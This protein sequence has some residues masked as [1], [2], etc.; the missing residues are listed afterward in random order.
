L[1]C[2]IAEIRE[3]LGIIGAPKEGESTVRLA[4]YIKETEGM[5]P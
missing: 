3:E 1:K 4:V 5:E 2:T